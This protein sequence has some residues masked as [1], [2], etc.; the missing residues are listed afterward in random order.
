MNKHKKTEVGTLSV[1]AIT[2][3]YDFALSHNAFI[4]DGIV[5]ASS[6][7]PSA[8]IQPAR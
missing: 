2:L 4:L 1:I 8:H 3:R 7:Y 6:S 5:I